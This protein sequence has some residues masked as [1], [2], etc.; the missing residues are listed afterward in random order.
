MI[1]KIKDDVFG[2]LIKISNGIIELCVTLD[3]G[4]RVIHFSRVG[5]ENMFYQ[6]KDMKTMGEKFDVFGGDIIKLYGGHRLWV[7]PENM[8]TCYYPDNQPV[9]FVENVNGDGGTFTSPI[10]KFNNIQKIISITMSDNDSVDICHTIKNCGA[11]TIKIAPWAITQLACGGKEIMPQPTTKTGYLHNRNYSFW[12]YAKMN[13]PRLYLGDKYMTLTQDTTNTDNF[14]MGY[15]NIEGF[16]M[17]VNLGQI[18]IKHTKPISN[19]NY[20]DSGCCFE[21]Y[22]NTEMLEMETLGE[23]SLVEPESSVVL[24]EKWCVYHEEKVPSNDEAE[25]KKL[26]EKYIK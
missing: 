19:G 11:Y 2:N 23:L 18:F 1:T 14:K 10:E 26:I 22:T 12:D 17:Y 3:F 13:D 9:D 15:N 5:K 16:A 8:P 7:S 25:L 20:P 24:E 21:T 6:D 4:P